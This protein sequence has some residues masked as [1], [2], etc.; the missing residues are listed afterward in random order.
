L[1][2]TQARRRDQQVQAWSSQSHLIH[3]QS[4]ARR[5]GPRY[6]MLMGPVGGRPFRFNHSKLALSQA[7]PGFPTERHRPLPSRIPGH[8]DSVGP[9][10][11]PGPVPLL[12]L[13]WHRRCAAV[14]R[15]LPKMCP[16]WLAPQSP[17]VGIAAALRTAEDVPLL[18]VRVRVMM[19]K[20][21]AGNKACPHRRSLAQGC[22]PTPVRR[23]LGRLR[24]M[25]TI[26]LSFSKPLIAARPCKALSQTKKENLRWQRKPLLNCPSFSRCGKPIMSSR[27]L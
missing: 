27:S 8:L 4:A 3:C 11:G 1:G 6:G 19:I 18:E 22:L 2:L 23:A 25:T 24:P 20:V 17:P 7:P 26:S 10:T 16:K 21:V 5:T 12:P 15:P 14:L 13:G 9:L